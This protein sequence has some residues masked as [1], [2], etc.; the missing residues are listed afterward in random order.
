MI[1]KDLYRRGDFNTADSL[2]KESGIFF[3][4]NFRY[5]FNDL[6]F[7]T[8]DLK[9]KDIESLLL[10]TSKNKNLLEN[11]KSNLHF[12]ALKLKVRR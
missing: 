4:Q 6:N 7:I 11:I 5:L 10:W 2:V 1:A 12:E 3:D 9:N 8:S